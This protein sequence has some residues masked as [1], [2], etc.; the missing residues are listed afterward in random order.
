MKLENKR[1]GYLSASCI[2]TSD[3]DGTTSSRDRVHSVVNASD[4]E[5]RRNHLEMLGKRIHGAQWERK[6][7]LDTFTLRT[8]EDSRGST[9]LELSGR[10]GAS[11]E[12]LLE[13]VDHNVVQIT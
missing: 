3:S 10:D 9:K 5:D 2:V 8:N 7:Y 4:I 1:R 6:K 13:L 11:T 12:L